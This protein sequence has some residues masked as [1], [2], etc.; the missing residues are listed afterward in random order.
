MSDAIWSLAA[1]A[2]SLPALLAHMR[3][4]AY[5]VLQPLGIEVT[6]DT[7]P[8][9]PALPLRVE[10][11]Q[12]LYLVFKE[13]LHNVVKHAPAATDVRVRLT[14]AHPGLALAV[15][16][17]GPAPAN[18]ALRPEGQGLSNMQ[19]RAAALGGTVQYPPQSTG[20]VVE[21]TLPG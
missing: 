15:H 13:A 14:P 12:A 6:F 20:F 10:S 3:D 5:E 18:A 7:D 17:N 11:R 9:V 4:H 8:A 1:T 16:N 19:A 21:L 2:P